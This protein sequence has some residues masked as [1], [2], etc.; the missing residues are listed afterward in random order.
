MRNNSLFIILLLVSNLLLSQ[1][2]VVE[3]LGANELKAGKSPNHQKLMG[4]VILKF[5]DTK[6]FCDSAE[7]N[8]LTNDFIATGKVYINKPNQVKAWGDQLDYDGVKQVGMLIGDVKMKSDGSLLKTDVLYFDEKNAL[9][10]YLNGANTVTNDAVIYSKKGF[11]DTNTKYLKLKDSVRVKNPG[12]YIKSDTLEYSTDSKTSYF[13]GPTLIELEKEQIYC[14]DGFYNQTLDVAQFEKNAIFKNEAQVLEADSIYFDKMTGIAKAYY[15]VKMQDTTDNIMVTGEE[16]YF[17]QKNNY[18][19]VTKNVLFMQGSDN[20]TLYLTSDTLIAT[21]DTAGNKSFYAFNNVQLFQNEMQ[22]ICD[23]L[24]YNFKDSLIRLYYDPVIWN[25]ES[26]ITG[27]TIEILSYD[28]KLQKLFI[29]RNG[30]I[31]SLTDSTP[32]RYD[33]IKGR[34]LVGYFKG[35]KM[36]VINVLGNGQTIYYAQEEDGKYSGVNKAICSNI[37]VKFKDGKV[38]RIKFITL[39]EAIFYPLNDFPEEE[40]QLDKFKW[41]DDDRPKSKKSLSG[42]N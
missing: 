31:V 23:S 11:Y 5:D 10:Y 7:V 40:S 8:S 34:D 33:Q 36:D 13:F 6:L 2:K 14:E 9:V 19:F 12:Y 32:M 15:N 17:D 18:S 27:D 30:F 26:Q 29:K 39:P 21:E 28:N 35:G 22:G 4:N 42:R 37:K 38:E 16:G 1:K 41:R 20:D 24:A 3:I 25:G